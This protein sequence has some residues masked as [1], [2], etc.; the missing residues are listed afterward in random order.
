MNQRN[1]NLAPAALLLAHFI[2]FAAF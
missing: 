1:I 2:S